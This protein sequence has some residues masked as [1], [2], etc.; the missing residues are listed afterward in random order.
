MT[1]GAGAIPVVGIAAGPVLTAGDSFLLARI[2]GKP[3]PAMFLSKN[4]RSIFRN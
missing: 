4:Y 3:G 1:S 2:I